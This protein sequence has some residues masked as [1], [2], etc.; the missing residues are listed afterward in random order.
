ML[1]V[2]SKARARQWPATSPIQLLFHPPHS[3]MGLVW[4]GGACWGAFA[5]PN[6]GDD[7]ALLAGAVPGLSTI[8]PDGT[9]GDALDECPRGDTTMVAEP[10]R[11]CDADAA[12][13]KCTKIYDTMMGIFERAGSENATTA[14]VADRIVEEMIFE[15]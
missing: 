1:Q 2:W 6:S 14:S 3:L 10:S 12:R 5:G 4:G 11:G 9:R 15:D 8:D 13:E 7:V